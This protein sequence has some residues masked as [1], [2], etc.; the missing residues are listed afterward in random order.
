MTGAERGPLDPTPSQT[1]GP[2]FGFALPY[3]GG[4]DLVDAGASGA[5]RLDGTVRDGAG[6]PVADA[7][8]EL[9]QP[10]ADGRIVRAPGSRRRGHEPFTGFGRTA[11]EV[12]GG[13]AFRTVV[14]GTG[15]A[16]LTVFARG[17]TH[18]LSTRVYFVH[19]DRRPDDAFLRRV[20]PNR[21]DTLFA[22][23]TGAARYRF[24]VTLQGP[25]ETVFLEYP[26]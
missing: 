3:A 2:F 12:D 26:A 16:L 1:I 17:L 19:G 18:H 24:D 4:G 23:R 22:L 13:Y 25:G 10:D 15:W 21:R 20:P 8:L 9:W 5:V 11:T 7:L 14:P 6:S